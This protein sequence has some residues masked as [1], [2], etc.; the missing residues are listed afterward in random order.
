MKG[1]R[2]ADRETNTARTLKRTTSIQQ[3]NLKNCEY[4]H[5]KNLKNNNKLS[6]TLKTEY[7][8]AL[9]EFRYWK[10][11]NKNHERGIKIKK[12]AWGSKKY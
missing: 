7:K 9:R 6:R 1:E 4:V 5:L 3:L 8:S 2:H 11:G 10:T 12:H